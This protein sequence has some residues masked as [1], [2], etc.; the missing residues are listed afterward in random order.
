[1][2]CGP[3]RCRRPGFRPRRR[4]LS[5]RLSLLRR[6][7]LLD[8]GPVLLLDRGTL[9]L[10]LGPVLLLDAG[11]LFLLDRRAL[12]CS[13]RL[14]LCAPWLGLGSRLRLGVNHAHGASLCRHHPSAGEC[15]GPWRRRNRRAALIPADA[16]FRV[17]SRGRFR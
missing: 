3:P 10:D 14:W 9:L 17:A 2:L 5:L 15:S 6:A 8:R 16:Q 11:T 12:R 13:L 4:T 1:M 7:P